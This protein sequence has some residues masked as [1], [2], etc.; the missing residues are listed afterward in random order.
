VLGS[1]ADDFKRAIAAGIAGLGDD[2]PSHRRTVLS[3]S[4]LR[5]R[6]EDA[7]KVIETLEAL[8]MKHDDEPDARTYGLTLAFYPRAVAEDAN[9]DRE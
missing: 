3:R 4:N 2:A 8:A 9:D 6:P 5:L 7:A 1:T